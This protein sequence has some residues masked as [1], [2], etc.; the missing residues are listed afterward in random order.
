MRMC[1]CVGGG[2]QTCMI[3]E[4]MDTEQYLRQNGEMI[5]KEKRVREQEERKEAEKF[6]SGLMEGWRE[7]EL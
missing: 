2:V 3:M 1:V 7:R 6:K 5:W 4:V